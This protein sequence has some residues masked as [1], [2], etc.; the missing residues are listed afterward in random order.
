MGREQRDVA[1]I[2]TEQEI[3]SLIHENSKPGD[4]VIYKDGSVRRG[5]KNGW[6][7]IALQNNKV[8]HRTSGATAAATTS[9]MTMEIV[10]ITRALEWIC[11]TQPNSTHLVFLT[12]S[13]STLRRIEKCLLRSGWIDAI[14]GSQLRSIEWIFCPG[15]AGVR[16]NEAADRLAG[17]ATVGESIMPDRADILDRL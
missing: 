10:A 2:V 11:R 17:E 7:L 12:D 8:M 5:V 6:G 15:H 3:L 1:D 14:Q 16:G 4:P 9:S 13:Q